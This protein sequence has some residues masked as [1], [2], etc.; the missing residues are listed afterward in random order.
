M[1]LLWSQMSLS[2]SPGGHTLA[3]W[4]CVVTSTS[5]NFCFLMDKMGGYHFLL[6][7]LRSYEWEDTWTVQLCKNVWKFS[8]ASGTTINV[9]SL[10]LTFSLSPFPSSLLTVWKPVFPV[11]IS[12]GLRTPGEGSPRMKRKKVKRVFMVKIEFTMN[13]HSTYLYWGEREKTGWLWGA[14]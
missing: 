1:R 6:W 8:I 2:Q 13:F 9:N 10:P 11:G 4:L 3:V 12:V 5:Q 14:E 7:V